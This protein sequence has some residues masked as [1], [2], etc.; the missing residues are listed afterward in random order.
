MALPMHPQQGHEHLTSPCPIYDISFHQDKKAYNVISVQ[1]Y[2]YDDI[3]L[4]II[5]AISVTINITL[6]TESELSPFYLLQYQQHRHH[7]QQHLPQKHQLPQGSKNI[8]LRIIFRIW[9][10][11]SGVISTQFRVWELLF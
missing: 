4:L 8:S 7:Q 9:Q 5:M 1:I 10:Q 11:S 3:T 6:Y 2:S